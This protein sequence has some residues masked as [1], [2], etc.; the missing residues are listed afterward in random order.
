ML[1]RTVSVKDKRRKKENFFLG[2]SCFRECLGKTE[3]CIVAERDLLFSAVV[4]S[5]Y[6]CVIVEER[7]SWPLSSVAVRG[8][9][10]RG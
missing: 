5:V 2:S 7:S 1:C 8:L 9:T 3:I 6:V 4:S 10:V